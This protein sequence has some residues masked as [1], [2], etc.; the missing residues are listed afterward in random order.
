MLLI[1]LLWQYRQQHVL[2]SWMRAGAKKLPPDLSLPYDEIAACHYRA[3]EQSR[4]RKRKRKRRLQGFLSVYHRVIN[5]IPDVALITDQQGRLLGFNRKA[6]EILG[7]DRRLDIGNKVD[8]MLRGEGAEGFWERMQSADSVLLRLLSESNYVLEFVQLFFQKG[9]VLLLAR[10]VSKY[11][12]EQARRKAFVENA[13]HELR[14]PLTVLC[15][16]FEIMQHQEDI[17]EKW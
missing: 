17:P 8:F 16:F 5:N 14:T 9:E 2:L 15:G 13:L 7:L 10:D 3:R 1:V 11:Y 6:Q 12:Q 4:K